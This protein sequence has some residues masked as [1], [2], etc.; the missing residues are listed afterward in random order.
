MDSTKSPSSLSPLPLL[1]ECNKKFKNINPVIAAILMTLKKDINIMVFGGVIRDLIHESPSKDVDIVIIQENNYAYDINNKSFVDPF[2]QLFK[3]TVEELTGLKLQKTNTSV[4]NM[5]DDPYIDNV[6]EP[7]EPCDPNDDLKE[8]EKD[9]IL[10]DKFV[11]NVDHIK[12]D[13]SLNDNNDNNVCYN[14]TLDVSFIK[15]IDDINWFKP[16]C[17]QDSLYVDKMFDIND[18]LNDKPKDV[19]NNICYYFEK[20]AKTRCDDKSVE[21]IIDD[22]K[23]SFIEIYNVD[24]PKRALK[25][26]RYLNE[27]YKLK[28]NSKEITDKHA[29]TINEIID[30]NL[31]KFKERNDRTKL[32]YVVMRISANATNDIV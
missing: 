28:E 8:L 14:F 19:L 17:Y 30:G 6:C 24:V 11:F 7:C 32:K 16:A 27:G 21:C 22:I 9:S 18:L 10:N 2:Y 15:N 5:I 12:Y 4:T 25:I 31:L 13:L 23:K 26:Y 1:Q 29:M 3:K 20:Y